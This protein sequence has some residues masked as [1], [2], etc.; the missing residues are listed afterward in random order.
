MN[1][2]EDRPDDTIGALLA[3]GERTDRDRRLRWDELWAELIAADARLLRLRDDLEAR[4]E[5]EARVEAWQ[6]R[7]GPPVFT[8]ERSRAEVVALTNRMTALAEEVAEIANEA[9]AVSVAAHGHRI[10][11]EAGQLWLAL[12]SAWDALTP[13]MEAAEALRRAPVKS[14]G[15]GDYTR[16]LRP[17]A[18]E[19]F[20]RAAVPIFRRVGIPLGGNAG[21]DK[22]FATF[23]DVMHKHIEGGP[24]PG[25]GK[26][27]AD[28]R[29]L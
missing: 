11:E 1:E 29:K 21:K 5:I 23:L 3:V 14:G 9:R 27:L 24:I 18:A 22:A 16:N 12:L 26:L 7:V 19:E 6:D 8:P 25:K 2:T 4:S 13:A 17:R 20:G 10:G 15:P 28:L